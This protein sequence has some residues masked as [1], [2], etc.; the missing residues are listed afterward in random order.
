MIFKITYIDWKIA[1]GDNASKWLYMALSIPQALSFSMFGIPMFGV[2]VSPPPP[3]SSTS[4][5]FNLDLWFQ[6][7]HRYGTL[8]PLDATLSIRT[9]PS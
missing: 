4:S 6:R 7:K 1:G 5:N 2:D 3:S 8:R 9:S